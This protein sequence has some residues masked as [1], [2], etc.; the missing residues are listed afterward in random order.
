MGEARSRTLN[1]G[2][3]Y[4]DRDETSRGC[5]LSS[6]PCYRD[7]IRLKWPE[8]PLLLSE[9]SYCDESCQNGTSYKYGS[10]GLTR[11]HLVPLC[12]WKPLKV[13]CHKQIAFVRR[14]SPTM[15]GIKS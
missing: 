3:V 6:F 5:R 7:K 1:R 2:T 14:S 12:N 10:N 13:C 4:I 8:A 15:A 9:E 11:V